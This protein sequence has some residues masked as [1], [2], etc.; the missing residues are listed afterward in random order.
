MKFTVNGKIILS[1]L[2]LLMLTNGL[3]VACLSL[4]RTA[5]TN[6]YAPGQEVV[7]ELTLQDG[8]A[9]AFSSLG[10]VESLPQGWK[11]I[12]GETVSGT[13]PVQWLAPGSMDRLEIFWITVPVF[14]VVLR[15]TAKAPETAA[16]TA[17]FSGYAVYSF[18]SGN[19]Q[20]SSVTETT[21]APPASVEGEGETLEGE[22]EPQP[23][24]EKEGEP[25]VEGEPCEGEQEGETS[26]GEGEVQQEGEG[27][28]ED[29]AAVGCCRRQPAADIT[30]RII[31]PGNGLMLASSLFLVMMFAKKL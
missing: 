10:I 6:S 25:A 12:A 31:L 4:T 27:E 23:E 3:A 2:L 19:Q 28:G 14:P 5:N 11:F 26:E 18:S 13:E 7:I 29:G 15:Y 8:C 1:M 9:E 21:L 16:S 24:G 20:N 30:E 17:L 22:G